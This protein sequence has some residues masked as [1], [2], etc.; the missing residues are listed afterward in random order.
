MMLPQYHE[1]EGE[2][3]LH[4]HSHRHGGFSISGMC[5]SVWASPESRNIFLFLLI[6]LTFAFVELFYG[7]LSNSLGLISDGIHMLFDCT[8]LLVGLIAS[9]IARRAANERFSFGYQRSE[10]LGG[11]INGLF[12][13]FIAFFILKEALER[14]IDPPHIH[15]HHLLPVA[16]IG[17]LVNLIG[18]FAFQHAHSHG[19]SH[20]GDDS[21]GHSHGHSHDHHDHHDHG[22]SHGHTHGH[23][24]DKKERRS[25]V[26]QGVLLH[27][28]ADT[29]GSVGVIISSLLI[30]QYG[31][32]LADPICSLFISIM[33]LASTYSLLKESI[34]ILMQRTPPKLDSHLYTC[35]R[36]VNK[37][38]GVI[39]YRDPHFW[40]LTPA[41]TV[42]S[43]SV[44]IKNDANDTAVRNEVLR[45]F[46]A[47][48]VDK[49]VVQV[50]RF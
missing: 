38:D 27:V 6:N 19:H 20:G 18:I 9:I 34:S 17:L 33:I 21:H 13:V 16:V 25:F 24:D 3:K 45:I 42:G 23:G 32:M 46:E 14:F 47:V 40:S 8:A 22:H 7:V 44:V 12:L 10:I 11:F 2:R 31:L 37:V 36:R 35:Y 30:K 15:T 39:S 26:M 4:G 43:L 1:E 28:I 50:E 49:M 48:G 5:R 41:Y 29:L